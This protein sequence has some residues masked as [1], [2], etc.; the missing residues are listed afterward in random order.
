MIG[1]PTTKS[2]EHMQEQL[3]KCMAGVR[4]TATEWGNRKLGCLPLTIEVAD[5]NIVTAGVLNSNTRLDKPAVIHKDIKDDT[6]Q[7]DLL[8]LGKLQDD[9]IAAYHVQEA[10]TNLGVAM[11]LASVE[12]Q[13]LVAINKRYVG[14]RNETLLS[15]LAH[16]TKT[17]V[18]V[19]NHKK[20]ACVEYFKFEWADDPTMHIKNY[21]LEL[22]K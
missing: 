13:Y 10:A 9:I 18:N 16:L 22:K 3:A 20:V 7:K 4:I 17:W 12:E 1:L 11:F 5:L 19:Q 2:V 14:F 6:G 21:A 8:C 15:I